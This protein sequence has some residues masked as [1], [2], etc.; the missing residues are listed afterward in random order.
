MKKGGKTKVISRERWLQRKLLS[1]MARSFYCVSVKEEFI[2]IAF[3]YVTYVI[4][5]Q[6]GRLDEWIFFFLNKAKSWE[7]RRVTLL[8]IIHSHLNLHTP[9]PLFTET[10]MDRQR[11]VAL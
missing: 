10:E 8:P 7:G 3:W 9:P 11:M 2:S 1:H 4:L 5:S 6:K